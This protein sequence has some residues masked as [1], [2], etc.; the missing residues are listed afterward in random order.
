[1]NFGPWGTFADESY[2]P[3]AERARNVGVGVMSSGLCKQ[4]EGAIFPFQVESPEDTHECMPWYGSYPREA[5]PKG[6]WIVWHLRHAWM[7]ALIRIV[8]GRPILALI[9]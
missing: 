1:M 8:G 6:L 5:A 2:A 4:L 7:R 3:Q 9:P